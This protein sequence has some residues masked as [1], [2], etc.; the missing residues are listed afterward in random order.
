MKKYFPVY[1]RVPLL[2]VLFYVLVE[3]V[4]GGTAQRPAFVDHPA[5]LILLGLFLFALIA[6]EIVASATNKVLNRL[7]SPEEIAAKEA[8]DNLSF[9][10]RPWV[11]KMMQKMTRTTAM[12]DEKELLMDHDYDG[13]K[14]LDNEL[15]P[16]WVGLFYVTVI[17]SVVYL[18]RFHVFGGDNQIVEYEKA[19]AIAKEQIEEY[20][21]TAADLISAEDAQYLTDEASLAAGKKIFEMNCVA[22]HQADGGGGI[23]PNLTDD[24]WILG[25][26][27]KNVFHTISEGGRP[28][29]GMVDWKKTL[30]PSEIEKVT[31]YVISLNGTTPAS[32]KEA[33]GDI[34]WS[35]A[36]LDGEG[37]AEVKV[38]ATET[39]DE[40]ATADTAETSQE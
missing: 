11:K 22:C 18:L 29:K 36:E 9:A 7:M 6:V 23:G 34:I 19:M 2:F 35:K 8:S 39:T 1:V 13:I 25:G 38:E 40:A 33:E 15:P 12:S 10:D 5:V 28:G 4:A 32:P 24:H 30:K 37:A 14:E 17:F 31:S 20:K 3:W 26:G 27:V 21:K 16:W